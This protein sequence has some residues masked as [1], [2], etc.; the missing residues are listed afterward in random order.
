LQMAKAKFEE[1]DLGGSITS[2][3]AC[4]GARVVNYPDHAICMMP[5]A[6]RA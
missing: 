3:A 6:M 4:R 1:V 5:M 2:R